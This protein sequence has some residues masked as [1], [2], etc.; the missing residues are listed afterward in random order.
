MI[1]AVIDTNILVSGFTD[2]GGAPGQIVDKWLEGAFQ[3]VTSAY[4]LAE[5]TRTFE[6]PYFRRH[7]SPDQ[8]AAAIAALRHRAR[9]TELTVGVSGVASH[10]EDDPVIATALSAG[11]PYLVTGD[12]ELRHVGSYEGVT[13]L[14]PREFL[15]LL[16]EEA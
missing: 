8:I 1:E 2:R 13:I 16:E 6:K 7:L 5:L 15:A 12:A 9:Q 10:P 4:I 14:T 3:I 11:V